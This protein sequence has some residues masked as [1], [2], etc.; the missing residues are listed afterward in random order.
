MSATVRSPSHSP[1]TAA[2]VPFSTVTDSGVSSTCRSR[3]GSKANR[4][5]GARRGRSAALAVWVG[6]V[7]GIENAQQDVAL[8]GQRRDGGG[9][10]LRGP[11]ALRHHLQG[12]LGV[13]RRLGQPGAEV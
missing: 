13:A 10:L 9:L 1:T 12:V 7:D 6:T 11:A 2:A 4:T 3:A 5:E 8:E